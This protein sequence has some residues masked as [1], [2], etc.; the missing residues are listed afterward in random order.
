MPN[1]Q[2]GDRVVLVSVPPTLLSGLPEEDQAAISS[3]IGKPATFAGFSYGQAEVELTDSQ[4]DDHT[5]WVDAD[6]IRP[7]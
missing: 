4:G 2:P 1:L 6:R 5:I 7:A 3:A